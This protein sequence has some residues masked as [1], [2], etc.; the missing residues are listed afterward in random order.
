MTNHTFDNKYNVTDKSIYDH[1]SQLDPNKT[2][3]AAVSLRGVHTPH[4]MSYFGDH[5]LVLGAPLVGFKSPARGAQ[6]AHWKPPA[7][8]RFVH[9]DII[10]IGRFWRHAAVSYCAIS[11]GRHH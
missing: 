6:V 4:T 2:V 7:M 1:E 11:Y 10:N 5:C 3:V 8:L 9:R